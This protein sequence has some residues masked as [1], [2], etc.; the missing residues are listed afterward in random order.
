MT[1]DYDTIP[2]NA[3]GADMLP[4]SIGVKPK[5]HLHKRVWPL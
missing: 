1:K 5:I 3:S 2:I 4:V